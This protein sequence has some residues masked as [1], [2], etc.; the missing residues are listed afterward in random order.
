MKIKRILVPTDFS[1]AAMDAFSYAI[2]F[3]RPFGAA[4]VVLFVV[5]PVFYAALADLDGTSANLQMLLQQEEKSGRQR[6][7]RLARRLE[8]RRVSFEAEVRTGQPHAVIV[9][10][11]TRRR[12]DLIIMGTHGRTGLSHLFMGSVA[13][14]VVRTAP[15]PVL[16]V[17]G[18]R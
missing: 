3:A 14:K 5:E 10:E 4:L 8:K 13:E 2:D 16:T 1:P 11:A 17:R 7:S 9:E 18:R 15:C 12:V 6:L